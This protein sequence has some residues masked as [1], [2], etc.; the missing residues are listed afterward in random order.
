MRPQVGS[1]FCPIPGIRWACVKPVLV[2]TGFTASVPMFP[3]G[4]PRV[5]G[6]TKLYKLIHDRSLAACKFGPLRD[7]RPLQGLRNENRGSGRLILTFEVAPEP[8]S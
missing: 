6:E 2:C 8:H 4:R 7:P 5:N 1:T 3:N